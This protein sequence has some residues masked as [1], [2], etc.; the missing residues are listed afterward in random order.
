MRG[1]ICGVLALATA[2][3]LPGAGQIAPN[4]KSTGLKGRPSS[5]P[6]QVPY[7]ATYQQ[8]TVLTRPNGGTSTNAAILV[9]VRDSEGRLMKST[10]EIIGPEATGTISRI[11]VDDP[12]SRTIT[13]WSLVHPG[14][15]QYGQAIIRNFTEVGAEP[16]PC[17]QIVRPSPHSTE[18]PNS[19][20][21]PSEDLAAKIHQ[22]FDAI[23]AQARDRNPPPDA[24]PKAKSVTENLGVKTI[25]GIEVRGHRT[26]MTSGA[27]ANPKAEPYRTVFQSWSDTTPGLGL[28]T[29]FESIDS[30]KRKYSRELMSIRLG[31]PDPA[32]FKPPPGF[33]VVD[34]KPT[35]CPVTPI[36][37][38]KP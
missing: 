22:R 33:E 19:A 6:T 28:L 15:K 32:L 3:T 1:T 20:N 29:V 18:S 27:N 12:V 34:Q 17:P 38:A 14:E 9:E 31:E 24:E 4:Q 5:R 25:E 10:T 7:S 37:S 11:S 2:L 16:T 21:S 26:T 35:G 23:R 36:S 8:T 30:P 13:F